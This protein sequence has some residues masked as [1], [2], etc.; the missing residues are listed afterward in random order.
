MTLGGLL[1]LTSIVAGM[2]LAVGARLGIAAMDAIVD[3]HDMAIARL[4]RWW[5]NRFRNADGGK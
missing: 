2:G 4:G 1:F 5:R 3:L